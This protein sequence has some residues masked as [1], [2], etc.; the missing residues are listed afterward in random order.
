[1][2]GVM[3]VEG[4]AASTRESGKSIL[5][6]NAVKALIMG[7]GVHQSAGPGGA[8]MHQGW[9][10]TGFGQPCLEPSQP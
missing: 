9:T 2:I 10:E 4:R 5:R 3:G 6:N 7:G 1:M 8:E